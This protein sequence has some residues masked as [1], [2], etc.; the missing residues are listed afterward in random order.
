MQP[1]Q[2]ATD[3]VNANSHDGGNP[4][5]YLM[6]R[7]DAGTFMTG[8]CDLLCQTCPGCRNEWQAAWKL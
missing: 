1:P 5:F 3:D 4:G 6:R 8:S 7:G 2:P